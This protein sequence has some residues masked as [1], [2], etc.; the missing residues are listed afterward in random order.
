MDKQI[1]LLI[2][3][4]DRF[5]RRSISRMIERTA[6]FI[7]FEA[8]SKDSVFSIINENQPDC[9]LMDYYM[10]DITGLELMRM[11]REKDITIPVIM[12][13]GQGDEEIAAAILKAGAYDY[14]PKKRLSEQ[15]FSKTL[16]AMVT[17]AI[18]RHEAVEESDRAQIAL[19]LSEARYRGL[20]ENSP[21]LIARF[22]PEDYTISFINDFFCSY[23]DVD[24]FTILGESVLTLIPR[25]NHES[26]LRKIREI[27]TENSISRFEIKTIVHDKPRW[28][29]WTVQGIFDENGKIAEF[30]AMG[31]DITGL[32]STQQELMEQRRYLQSILDSQDNM[33]VVA[34]REKIHEVNI[35]FLQFFGFYSY[36]DM[37]K[38]I[39]RI[40]EMTIE[41]EGC[42]K[43]SDA[44]L[45]WLNELNSD[46]G[47]GQY[48]LIA[49]RQEGSDNPRYFSVTFRPLSIE[50][51]IFVLEFSDV[52]AL[53]ERSREFETRANYDALTR[54]FNRRRF[55]EL[56]EHGI[57][58]ARKLNHELSII[59]FDIDH[60][61]RINDTY[62]HNTGDDVLRG[63][64]GLI[65]K[66]IRRTDIFARW[67]GEEFL[68]LLE[69]TSIE[70]AARMAEKLR[71]TIMGHNFPEVKTVTC[72]FGVTAY[73]TGEKG[74]DLISRAD[75]A[76]YKAKES[77]RNRVVGIKKKSGN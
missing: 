41:T 42:L 18:S 29:L 53:E 15:D 57:T 16:T 55:L 65:S 68:I 10:A 35:S 47:I 72:S 49:F 20:I 7:I 40:S 43:P 54:I 58:S 74:D 22:F 26:S 31:E 27:T 77:G 3:D 62:G 9:I 36:D 63:L 70:N 39:N 11:F 71:K 33:I 6:A 25:S 14:I 61:K 13:T 17:N 69:S 19:Q 66:T 1:K 46:E 4:D 34:D 37:E 50:S 76:L 52:T 21:I 73:A 8:D 64:A 28:Q 24:R 2:A 56:L 44:K 59:F 30:Q 5:I 38:N 67:G 23:F 60:F 32:K 75:S 45:M 48:R 12:I 51:D